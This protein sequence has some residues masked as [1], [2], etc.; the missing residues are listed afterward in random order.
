MCGITGIIYRDRERPVQPEIL[1][2]MC[3]T[4][5]HRGP[6]DAGWFVDR[7][8]GLGMR[9]LSVID[10]STGHQP[11]ASDDGQIQLVFNGEMYNYREVRHDLVG[12]GYVFTTQSDTETV[13]R[14]YEAYGEACIDQFNGMFALAIWDGHRQQL[15]LVRDRLGIKPLYYTVNAHGLMFGSEPKAIL[16]YPEMSRAINIEAL[17]CYLTLE[18]IP[19]PLSIFEGVQKLRPGHI[20]R[21][22]DGQVSDWAYWQLQPQPLKGSPPELAEQLVD[23]LRDAVRIRL[24]SDV[25]LGAFLS[26]GIDSSAIVGFMSEIMAQPVQTF[27]IGFDDPSY[28]ELHHARAAAEHFGAEHHEMQVQPHIVDLVETLIQYLDEPLADVSIFPTYLVSQLARQTVTVALSGDGGDELFAGYDW[29]VASVLAQ[30]YDRLPLRVRGHWLPYWLDR[31]PPTTQKKGLINACKRFVEGACL[32]A[33]LEHYRWNIFLTEVDKQQLYS[34]ALA[35]SLSP[36]RAYTHL[37]SHLQA[38]GPCDALWRRQHADIRTFL[39]DDILVKVDRMSMANSL[40]V[41][42]PFLDHRLVAFAAGLPRHQRL[43]GW[44][45]KYLLKRS[46]AGTLPHHIRHRRKEGFSIPMKNWLRQALHP[47]LQE[48]LSPGRLKHEGLFHVPYVEQLKAEHHQGVA[49][50][51]HRLWSLMM[52]EIWRDTYLTGV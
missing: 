16:A 15:L 32:P 6:D 23:L 33:E 8:V 35:A 4:L 49:N 39:L 24:M 19:T 28:N 12:R 3:D 22:R 44:Q 18:Y 14:A 30:Y 38:A 41:R 5:A 26:G 51:S 20:L 21:W 50:H 25:P 29:Y 52:F 2:R 47:L 48:V 40:E 43:R 7:H 1:Q 34:P 42:T 9:R 36:M 11:M 17:D 13:L 10:P 45:T 46:L 31:I 37:T 27:S